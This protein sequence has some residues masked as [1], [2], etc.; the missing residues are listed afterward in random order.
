MTEDFYKSIYDLGKLVEEMMAGTEFSKFDRSMFELET[1]RFMMFLIASSK[2][3]TEED[4]ELLNEYLLK[5][6][7]VKEIQDSIT[8]DD[9]YVSRFLEEM[10]LSF[11]MMVAFDKVASQAYKMGITSNLSGKF[12]DL[13]RFLGGEIVSTGNKVHNEDKKNLAAYM[14]KLEK[15]RIEKLT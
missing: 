10:P 2:V 4:A 13:Y 5:D 3:V 8:A 11:E 14:E 1:G 12:I 7:T 15:Y 9:I 6:K